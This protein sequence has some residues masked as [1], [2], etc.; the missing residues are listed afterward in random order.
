[1]ATILQTT[2]ANVFLEWKYMKF[3]YNIS[4]LC[5]Q[6]FNQQ[7]SISGT[8]TGLV[9]RRQRTIIWTNDGLVDWHILEFCGLSLCNEGGWT[10]SISSLWRHYGCDGVSNHQPCHRL[11]SHLFRRRSLT[12][13][14]GFHRWAVNSSHRWPVTRKMLPFHDVIMIRHDD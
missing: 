14:R 5:S 13:V 9:P 1:M 12:F 8:D 10:K 2:S 4:E 7:Y 3:Y 11:L 6:V